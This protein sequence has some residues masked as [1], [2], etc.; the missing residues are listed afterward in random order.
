MNFANGFN[1]TTSVIHVVTLGRA[2]QPV[3]P[4]RGRH[5]Q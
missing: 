3:Q 1:L 4:L 2:K 5:L